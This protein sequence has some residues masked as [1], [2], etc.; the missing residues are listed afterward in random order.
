MPRRWSV[1]KGALLML[2]GTG[3]LTATHATTENQASV[4]RSACDV[5][6]RSELVAVLVCRAD[7]E[8][9]ALVEAGKAACGVRSP[10]NAWMWDDASKAPVKAPARDADIPKATAAAAIGVW[11]ND[12]RTFVRV[13]R[14]KR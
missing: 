8:E 12:T 4:V 3:G 13:R 5:R 7:L 10:C 14:A 6:S 9:A 1:L 2:V 11:A